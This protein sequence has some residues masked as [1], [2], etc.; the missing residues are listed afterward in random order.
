M[1]MTKHGIAL[2]LERAVEARRDRDGLNFA[3]FYPRL[4][5]KSTYYM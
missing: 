4:G 2:R 3:N 1:I 5:I